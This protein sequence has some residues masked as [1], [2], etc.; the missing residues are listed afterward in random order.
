MKNVFSLITIVVCLG[1]LLHG[2][3]KVV[4]PD[5]M[6]LSEYLSGAGFRSEMKRAGFLPTLLL[7]SGMLCSSFID[8]A[9][10]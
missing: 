8:P 6:F 4:A 3:G 1:A 2:I 9:A 7:S 5:A 10:S